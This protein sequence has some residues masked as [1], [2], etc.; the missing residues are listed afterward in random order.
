MIPEIPYLLTTY[1][2][3]IPSTIYTFSNTNLFPSVVDILKAKDVDFYI[4]DKY[5][6][7]TVTFR[8]IGCTF[9]IYFSRL[10]LECE[11][12]VGFRYIVDIQCIS[13]SRNIGMI[14]VNDVV[15][16]LLHSLDCHGGNLKINK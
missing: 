11:K 9:N 5:A 16:I 7:L 13:R 6:P 2:N 3:H 12:K 1:D 8:L 15:R 4:M 10:Y 14:N